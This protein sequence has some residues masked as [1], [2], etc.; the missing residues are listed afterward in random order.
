[1]PASQAFEPD[2]RSR[3]VC[4]TPARTSDAREALF[5]RLAPHPAGRPGVSDKAPAK[6]RSSQFV[7]RVIG[8]I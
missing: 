7:K 8:E 5:G 2:V 6:F 4:R 3:C 1:M